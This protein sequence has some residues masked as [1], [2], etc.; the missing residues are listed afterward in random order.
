M[1][2]DW[3][4]L[5]EFALDEL[6]EQTAASFLHA[7]AVATTADSGR[8]YTPVTGASAVPCRLGKP[9]PEELHGVA[10]TLV[11]STA[12]WVVAF[13]AGSVHARPRVRYVVTGTENGVSFTRT[14]FAIGILTPVAFSAEVRVLCHED[15]VIAAGA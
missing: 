12:T 14:L 13:V 9:R 6:R 2:G 11:H 3:P 5:D 15:P 8:T 7:C 1:P 10:D 4:L